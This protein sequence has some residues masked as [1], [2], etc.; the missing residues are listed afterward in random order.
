MSAIFGGLIMLVVEPVDFE[1]KST[2]AIDES[3]PIWSAN[4][5]I[6]K[7]QDYIYNNGKKYRATKDFTSSKSPDLDSENFVDYGATNSRA[8]SDEL[9]HSQ[10]TANGDLLITINVKERVS[11]IAFL[12]CYCS[13]IEIPN[14]DIRGANGWV[15]S[16]WDY[17]FVPV[18]FNALVRECASWWQYF[19]GGFRVKKDIFFKL[20]EMSGEIQ[21]ILR[22]QDGK[23]ALG[24]L[25]VGNSQYIGE[26]LIQP[27]I[28]AISYAKKT[29]DEW[30][31]SV[32]RKG[33]TAK[34]ANYMVVTQTKDAD[35]I[36][37]VL[38]NARNRGL[39][40]FVG[41]SRASDG[42]DSLT[43][44]GIL[45]D[46]SLRVNAHDYSELDLSFEGVI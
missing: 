31:N 45:S 23:S 21:I 39:S 42:L 1:I 34:R 22:A 41:D 17:F 32:V 28:S 12:N 37:N 2:S 40:L 8:F 15:Q 33:K 10:T 46:Y 13:R 9:L 19:Y 4:L 3:L 36:V 7:G 11:T 14:L 27:E 29:T 18:G 16:W 6:K 24:M 25:I 5:A 44:F 43:I 30:G 38:D 20:P 26:T 35:R